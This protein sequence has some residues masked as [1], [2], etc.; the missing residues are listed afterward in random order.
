MSTRREKLHER[1]QK[2]VDDRKEQLDGIQAATSVL[3]ADLKA[4][5]EAAVAGVVKEK[6]EKMEKTSARLDADVVVEKKFYEEEVPKINEDQTGEMIRRMLRSRESFDIDNTNLRTREA[7]M[8]ARFQRHV[9][10][11]AERFDAEAEDRYNT[12]TALR[13]ALGQW[14]STSDRCVCV[15][16]VCVCACFGCC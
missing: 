11:T 6:E 4:E 13:E 2:E 1:I 8:I 7:A 10:A 3:L 16:V 12:S 14:V 9:D 5:F 15:M